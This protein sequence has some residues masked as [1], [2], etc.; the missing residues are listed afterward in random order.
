MRIDSLD[1]VQ[2]GDLMI[3]GQNTAPAKAV[4]YLGQILLHEHFRIGDFV[5]G[6]VGV[7][8]PPALSGGVNR[9]VEAMP[10]GARIRNLTKDDWTNTQAYL[11]LPDDYPGQHL[12]AAAVAMAMI[13][14]PNSIASYAYL[15]AYLGGF[16]PM[17]LEHRIDRRREGTAFM[18]PSGRFT[19]LG[20]GV[21]VLPGD[22]PHEAICS[23]LGEQSWTLTGKKVLHG[24][25]FQV[26]TP[27]MLAEQLWDRD[28][29]IKGAAWFD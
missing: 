21:D 11:R 9:L 16:K 15:G 26:A 6:H 27:G 5:A 8:V 18:L 23:V 7:V 29:V 1:D 2:P 14:T 24:T 17:W 12:D 3:A 20:S 10:G 19:H 4:V 25:A 13:G 28:G 22:L